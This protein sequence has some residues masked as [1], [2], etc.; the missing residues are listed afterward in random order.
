MKFQSPKSGQ[1]LCVH[2][3]YFLMSVIYTGTHSDYILV[4]FQLILYNYYII[5]LIIMLVKFLTICVYSWSWS[6]LKSSGAIGSAPAMQAMWCKMYRIRQSLTY[7]Y[8]LYPEHC[9]CYGELKTILHLWFWFVKKL[10]GQVVN[11]QWLYLVVGH[12]C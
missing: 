2:K 10:I 6:G 11:S 5:L 12:L 3:P 7:L 9:Q 1:I 4:S 8:K